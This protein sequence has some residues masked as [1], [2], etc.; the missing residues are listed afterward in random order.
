MN[1]SFTLKI[2]RGHYVSHACA[3]LDW[4][5][6]NQIIYQ[7]NKSLKDLL[8]TSKF[9]GFICTFPANWLFFVEFAVSV[10]LE[11]VLTFARSQSEFLPFA[12]L[13]FKATGSF[14]VIIKWVDYSYAPWKFKLIVS[15]FFIFGF[16][17]NS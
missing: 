3:R 10:F 5:L 7:H 1:S 17:S 8:Q 13:S 14:M 16:C 2:P 9:Y 4:I 12:S 15:I 6:L 11:M